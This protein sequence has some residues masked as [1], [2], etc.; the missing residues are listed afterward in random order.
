MT[1]KREE[2]QGIGE[3]E[4][5]GERERLKKEEYLMNTICEHGV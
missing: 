4:G 5:V 1:Q 3:K 2:R